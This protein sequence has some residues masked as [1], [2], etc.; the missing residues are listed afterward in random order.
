MPGLIRRW[1]ILEFLMAKEHD[2]K[3]TI[4]DYIAAV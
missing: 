2:I 3:N 4:G 1:V